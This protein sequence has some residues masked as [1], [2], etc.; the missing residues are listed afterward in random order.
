M[1]TVTAAPM[2]TVRLRDWQSRLA[3]LVEARQA[4]PFAWGSNDCCLFAADCA[5]ACL[6]VDLVA[7]LRGR[8]RDERS[9]LRLL[10]HLGGLA[11]LAG[12]RL[13]AE[14][15]PR[16]AQVGDVG[17]AADEATGELLAVWLGAHW[18]APGAAGLRRVA[19]TAIYRTW[20]LCRG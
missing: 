1:T 5:Q 13:G 9:A 6:G 19:P 18:A 16:M 2:P 12:A 14:V 15:Q 11:V 10:K 17:L 8:Y 4:A 3:A 7:D 20:R